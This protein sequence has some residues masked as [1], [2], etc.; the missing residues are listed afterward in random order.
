VVRTVQAK[1]PAARTC[2]EVDD[3][4]HR[5]MLDEPQVRQGDKVLAPHRP[6]PVDSCLLIGAISNSGTTKVR[7][8]ARGKETGFRGKRDD[9]PQGAEGCL[10]AS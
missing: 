4:G 8:I 9:A 1:E 2:E 5:R 7:R 6:M 3:E 10:H